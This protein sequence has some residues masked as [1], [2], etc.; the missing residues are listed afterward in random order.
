MSILIVE[1]MVKQNP[2]FE[3]LI[4]YSEASW[5]IPA[6]FCLLWAQKIEAALQWN[7]PKIQHSELIDRL[8]REK[9]FPGYHEYN[10]GIIMVYQDYVWVHQH[11]MHALSNSLKDEY[12]KLDILNFYEF[13]FAN[14][15]HDSPEWISVVGDIPTP[16]KESFSWHVLQVHQVY[17][18]KLISITSLNLLDPE[19]T[20]FSK[21]KM[22]QIM[23]ESDEKKTLN[24]QMNSYQDKFDASM[25]CLH[26]VHAWNTSFFL[27]KLEWYRKFFLEVVNKNKLSLIQD[28]SISIP[29]DCKKLKEIYNAQKIAHQLSQVITAKD[30]ISRNKLIDA[31][32]VYNIWKETTKTLKN[33]QVWNEIMNWVQILTQKR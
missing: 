33:I 24:S 6:Q 26:E 4:E 25:I 18:Q 27:E 1:F 3:E 16:I 2:S 13:L 9:R 23:K 8:A 7:L 10:K 31:M 11:R 15:Y 29:N 30:V 5:A 20:G 28:F 14:L 21:D 17:E 32:E 12:V 19:I 22:L